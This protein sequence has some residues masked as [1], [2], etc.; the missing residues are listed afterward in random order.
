[1]NN[2]FTQ[3]LEL[4]ISTEILFHCIRSNHHVT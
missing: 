2:Y 3:S 1:M 4:T